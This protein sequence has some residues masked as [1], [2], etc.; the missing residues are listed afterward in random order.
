[1]L[2]RR[3]NNRLIIDAIN[4]FESKYH[5]S[6]EATRKN[7][8]EF[9][10]RYGVLTDIRLEENDFKHL[11]AYAAMLK[12]PSNDEMW[13]FFKEEN[14]VTNAKADAFKVNYYVFAYMMAIVKGTEEV[15]KAIRN[16][17]AGRR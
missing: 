8:R 17:I 15:E 9:A 3:T 11:T 1:M 6:E 2:D 4:N 16:S 10:M 14:K 5:M 7:L 13:Y 12:Y